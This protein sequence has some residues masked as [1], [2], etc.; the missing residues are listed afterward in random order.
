[1]G[2]VTIVNAEYPPGTP[3]PFT[4]NSI[5]FN[6]QTGVRALVVSY[7]F[8]PLS[9]RARLVENCDDK[10][11]WDNDVNSTMEVAPYTVCA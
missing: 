9:A 7:A 4:A 5:S 8:V 3:V 6:I 1:M 2:T 11:V 10:T